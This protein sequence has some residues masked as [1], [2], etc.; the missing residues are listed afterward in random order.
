MAHP[1]R[2]VQLGYPT[3]VDGYSITRE[4]VKRS[5]ALQGRLHTPPAAPMILALLT[6]T[7]LAALLSTPS[8][9]GP[10][11]SPGSS[12]RLCDW[13]TRFL[14]GRT[15]AAASMPITATPLPGGEGKV[16]VFCSGLQLAS[17]SS[18]LRCRFGSGV[19]VPAQ[20]DGD[21]VSCCLG[22]EAEV[23]LTD[24]GGG[25][26]DLPRAQ[27]EGRE[28]G[29]PCMGRQDLSAV[30]GGGG[31]RAP[32]RATPLPALA[33]RPR[34]NPTLQCNLHARAACRA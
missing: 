3:S 14:A 34:G 9:L 24:G 28:R 1:G 15:Q 33:H 17:N 30:K 31:G 19:E 18:G 23:R 7:S 21:G 25:G 4:R 10:S 22:A 26:G 29:C 2:A 32:G 8:S 16:R 20:Q 5:G 27:P 13:L 6:Y 11:P 12:R